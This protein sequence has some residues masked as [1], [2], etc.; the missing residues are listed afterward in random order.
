M[1]PKKPATLEQLI[2]VLRD[3]GFEVEDVAGFLKGKAV[4]KPPV[5]AVQPSR[6]AD[7]QPRKMKKR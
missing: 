7:R 6:E 3:S 4:K 5:P 1:F 2:E